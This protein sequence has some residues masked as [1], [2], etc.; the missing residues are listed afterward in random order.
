MIDDLGLVEAP[1][2]SGLDPGI[3]EQPTTVLV[4]AEQQQ[5][6]DSRHEAPL[7]GRHQPQG[8]QVLR[9]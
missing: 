2:T 1:E 7:M 5:T 9:P 4:T 8:L 3:R 6:S